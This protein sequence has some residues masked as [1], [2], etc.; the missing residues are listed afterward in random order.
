MPNNPTPAPAA[1]TWTIAFQRESTQQLDG[2]GL[3]T[4]VQIGFTTRDGV[5]QSV[6]VPYSQYNPERV[7]EIIA[8][9]VANIDA[10]HAL[11][12]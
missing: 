1:P 8:A 7:K 5:T 2:G 3:S 10:I 9:R 6:F 11:T 12:G 4:G